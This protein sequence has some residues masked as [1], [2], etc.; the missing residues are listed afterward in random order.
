MLVGG[1]SYIEEYSEV[2]HV[3][4]ATEVGFIVTLLGDPTANWWACKD[5]VAWGHTDILVDV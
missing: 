2:M 1:Y 5:G 3:D 4:E